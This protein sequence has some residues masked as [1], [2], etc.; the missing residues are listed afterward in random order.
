MF[1]GEACIHP[2]VRLCSISGFGALYRHNGAKA[3][4]NQK[5]TRNKGADATSSHVRLVL[6]G[7]V[8]YHPDTQG[9]DVPLSCSNPLSVPVNFKKERGGGMF[10]VLLTLHR[11]FCLPLICS[12][13]ACDLCWWKQIPMTLALDKGKL[14][15]QDYTVTHRAVLGFPK[16]PFSSVFTPKTI[17]ALCLKPEALSACQE[18]QILSDENRLFLN[19]YHHKGLKALMPRGHA[20]NVI[21]IMIIPMSSLYV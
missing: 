9:F 7:P 2:P 6:S 1:L 8:T 11:L 20:V 15:G 5:I 18:G 16:A 14:P 3:D 17:G 13:S 19:K 12:S 21:R 10:C 4:R